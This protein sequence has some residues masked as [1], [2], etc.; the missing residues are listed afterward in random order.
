MAEAILGGLGLNIGS[1]LTNLASHRIQLALDVKRELEKLKETV[2]VIGEELQHVEELQVVGMSAW[3]QRIKDAAYEAEDIIDDFSRIALEQRSVIKTVRNF[4]S[5]SNPIFCHFKNSSRIKEVREKLSRIASDKS[6]HLETKLEDRNAC[7]KERE[8][9]HS[10]VCDS[11]VRGRDDDKGKIVQLLLCTDEQNI[12]IIPIQGLGGLGKTTLSQFVYNDERVKIFEL[13][14]WVYVSEDFDVKKVIEKIIKS[15]T[16]N[17]CPNLEM[18]QLQSRLREELLGRK[19][20]LVLDDVWNENADKWSELKKL[21]IGGAKGSKIL[22]TTRSEKVA[23]ITGT[24]STYHL[25]KLTDDECWKLFNQSALVEG[26]EGVHPNL[27][28]TG[29]EIARKCR[30]V[31]L[32]AKTLGSLLCYRTEEHEWEHIRDTEIFRLPQEEKSILPIL[33]LS[34]NHLPSSF[35]KQC[36]SFCSIFPK[37]YLLEKEML[38]QL[39]AALDFLHS[40]EENQTLEDVGSEFVKVLLWRSLFQDPKFDHYKNLITFK[41]HDLVHDL[42]QSIAGVECFTVEKGANVHIPVGVRHLY[43]HQEPLSSDSP[44][45][46]SMTLK[47]RTLFIQSHFTCPNDNFFSSFTSLRVLILKDFDSD[48]FPSSIGKLKHLRYLEICSSTIKTLPKSITQ[49]HSLQTLKLQCEKLE[50]LPSAIGEMI[51][52]GHIYVK[53]CSSLSYMPVGLEQLNALQTLSTFLVSKGGIGCELNVLSNLE[54]L[55]GMLTIKNLENASRKSSANA[56][57]DK[58]QNLQCLKAIWNEVGGEDITTEAFD[59]LDNL[60]PH[61]NLT[62]LK[63]EGYGGASFP[64]WVMKP[65]LPVLTKVTLSKCRRCHHLPPFGQLPSLKFLKLE[66]MDSIRSVEGLQDM[67]SLV[68]LKILDC[69]NLISL[70]ATH[71]TALESIRLIR[72]KRLRVWEM[73]GLHSLET[74]EIEGIPKLQV[75]PEGLQEA[76]R[77]RILKV[78]YCE[79]LLALPG[80]LGHY[81]LLQQLTINHCESLMAWENGLERLA[82]LEF[83]HISASVNLSSPPEELQRLTALQFLGISGFTD[84]ITLP[85]WLGNLTSLRLLHIYDCPYLECLPEWMRG[86]KLLEELHIKLCHYL[87]SRCQKDT[88]EDWANIAHVPKIILNQIRIQ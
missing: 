20:L 66:K 28:N 35:L 61:R 75:L 86:F 31:P 19:F 78:K 49:L 14:M 58:K 79:G 59:V 25:S 64:D 21:L 62:R 3:I 84:L 6:F 87:T 34:Y 43:F 46:L 33:K 40:P 18:D 50:A 32:A 60:K 63:L 42:S 8:Y 81:T 80:G 2:S 11:E 9:T 10:H 70:S 69:E 37:N 83:L 55:G 24:T 29:K 72:C 71:L 67:T 45:Y 88:G 74:L 57:L 15:A 51:Y 65:V 16:N 73:D 22:V 56:N 27:V 39:W 77:L 44:S 53:N 54:R 47:V 85:E 30:G 26:Q 41:M 48:N 76:I 36:F 52:L 7:Y 82:S 5:S 23:S 1:H 4:V 38:I 17:E 68:S 13:K 12:S